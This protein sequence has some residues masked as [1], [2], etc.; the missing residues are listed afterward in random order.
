MLRA[1]AKNEQLSNAT[2]QAPRR[3]LQCEGCSQKPWRKLPRFARHGPEVK[4]LLVLIY[5][6][7]TSNSEER[8]ERKLTPPHSCVH[9]INRITDSV[10]LVKYQWE[11]KGRPAVRVHDTS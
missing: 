4:R 2:D 10:Y 9:S 11:S 5:H 8:G 3:S 7:V 1:Q 6:H